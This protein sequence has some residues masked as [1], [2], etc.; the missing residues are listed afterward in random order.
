MVVANRLYTAQAR[1]LAA[2]NDVELWDRDQLVAKL[3]AGQ[4]AA[5]QA[6]PTPNA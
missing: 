6:A 5:I 2:D 3:L 4:D 1:R